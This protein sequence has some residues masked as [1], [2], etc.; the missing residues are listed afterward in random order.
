MAF[1]IVPVKGLDAK[2]DSDGDLLPYAADIIMTAD[3]LPVNGIT[4]SSNI[5][6][7]NTKWN[8][9][10]NVSPKTVKT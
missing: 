10:L 4:L 1:S 8:K 6:K 2:S 7:T 9:D 5:L 3:Q